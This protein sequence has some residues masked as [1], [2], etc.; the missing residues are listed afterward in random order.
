M[1]STSSRMVRSESTI[2]QSALSLKII[3]SNSGR[4]THFYNRVYWKHKTI[5]QWVLLEHQCLKKINRNKSQ[6]SL[7]TVTVLHRHEYKNLQLYHN[8]RKIVK[9]LRQEI[10][11]KVW[12]NYQGLKERVKNSTTLFLNYRTSSIKHKI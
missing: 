12:T 3:R 2:F 5:R 1:V 11:W 6:L 8:L 4:S 9:V 7:Q 10:I